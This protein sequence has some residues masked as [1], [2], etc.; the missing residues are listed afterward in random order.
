MMQKHSSRAPWCTASGQGTEMDN[1]AEHVNVKN[2]VSPH[3]DT[4]LFRSR[5]Q[6]KARPAH[7]LETPY[8]IA[9]D[10]SAET[11]SASA[12]VLPCGL[13]AAAPGSNRKPE[14]IWAGG[15]A[16]RSREGEPVVTRRV[17]G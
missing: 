15:G 8:A 11:R 2:V 17:R 9:P 10:V 16:Q 6:A 12:L 5:L 7:T 13:R 4:V 3:T 1:I 14:R